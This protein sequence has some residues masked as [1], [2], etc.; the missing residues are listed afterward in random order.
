MN[1]TVLIVD[2][3]RARC[4][5][6][7]GAL[8]RAFK[9]EVAMNVAGAFDI[10]QLSMVDAIVADAELPDMDCL[11]F[12]QRLDQESRF[13]DI[14]FVLLMGASGIPGKVTAYQIG[15]DDCISKPT[16][17]AELKA[18]LDAL[19]RKR[20]RLLTAFRERRYQLAGDFSGLAFPDVVSILDQGKHSGVL[21][22]LTT[23]YAARMVFRAGRI[24]H[25]TCGNIE[26]EEAFFLV[27]GQKQGQFEFSPGGEAADA[28]VRTIEASC[29]G[30]LMEAARR[31][32]SDGDQFDSGG[33][34]AVSGAFQT[35]LPPAPPPA[36]ELAEAFAEGLADPF[37]LGELRYLSAD[38]LT[39][40]TCDNHCGDRLHILL[41][42]EP[43]AGVASLLALATPMAESE[44][45][46]GMSAHAKT[47]AWS[48]NV[49]NQRQIDCVLIDAR[50]P[51]A[52][53]P[54]LRRQPA[55]VILAPPQGDA[56]ALGPQGSADCQRLLS[57]LSPQSVIGLGNASLGT[58][59]D[60]L[61]GS[62]RSTIAQRCTQGALGDPGLDMRD[63]LIEGIRLW[64][65]SQSA[66][67]SAAKA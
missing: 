65:S 24:I 27:M 42:A 17:P 64:A 45:L 9:V 37:M 31:L 25:A 2:A 59:L 11:Q 40:W 51:I 52:L 66:L 8:G 58:L 10:L 55:L 15:V 39:E 41:V 50:A 23:R 3:D 62:K 30:L 13:R 12:R 28:G 19:I 7:E 29:A 46:S 67:R 20:R 4:Q 26:G 36:P 18:R 32:D 6:L 34:R 60:D 54:S 57:K 35:L 63:L 1:P 14:P 43:A 44:V 56:L 38:E 47:L 49:R 5:A 22:V 33:V 61:V 21:S 48:F 53:L 16:D